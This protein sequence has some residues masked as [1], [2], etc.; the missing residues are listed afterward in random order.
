MTVTVS[1]GMAQGYSGRIWVDTLHD[2]ST[3]ITLAST[4][5]QCHIE[6]QQDILDESTKSEEI[7]SVS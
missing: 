7:E 1:V 4:I 2:T 5:L 6:S 3:I